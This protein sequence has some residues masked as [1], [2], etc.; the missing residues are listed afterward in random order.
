MSE[1]PEQD[2][3]LVQAIE[4]LFAE[5]EPAGDPFE[6]AERLQ[7]WLDGARNTL[8]LE[9]EAVRRT[10]DE[11]AA[12][13]MIDELPVSVASSICLLGVTGSINDRW[14]AE[15]IARSYLDDPEKEL[16]RRLAAFSTKT[17]QLASRDD[18]LQKVRD[19]GE[20]ILGWI[21]RFHGLI[22]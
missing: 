3:A 16:D 21:D 14:H 13:A 15:S 8:A 10:R 5:V 1:S 2:D 22:D 9:D 17:Q 18:Q 7:R 12:R 20:F 19:D 4:A 11:P 6:R